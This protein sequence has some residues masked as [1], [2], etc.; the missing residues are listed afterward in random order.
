VVIHLSHQDILANAVDAVLS[1]YPWG[2]NVDTITTQLVAQLPGDPTAA[3]PPSRSRAINPWLGPASLL[4]VVITWSFG[5][6]LSKQ[7]TTFP[8]VSTSVRVIVA[9]LVQWVI[10]AALRITPSRAVL[11]S[12]A[13]PGALFCVNNML[14]FF[15]LKHASV[16][17]TVLL[18]SLQPIVV[19]FVAQPLF[20]ERVTKWDVGWT[21]VSLGGAAVAVLGANAGAHTV[22][23]SNLG[24][25]FALASML[26]F[27]GY[28]L[29]GKLHNSHHTDAA[30]NPFTYMTAVLTSSGLTS[31][32]F[33]LLSGHVKDV[34]HITRH[35]AFGLSLVIVVPT[36]GHVFLTFAHR[37]VDASVSSLVLLVQPI[38]S[39]LLAWWILRERLVQAQLVGGLIVIVGIAAVTLR[40]RNAG[41]DA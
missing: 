18:A 9:A 33:L 16:A 15:A 29:L 11:K 20:G 24:A 23:T 31:I 39:G 32:P 19:L 40:K 3:L 10:C 2:G 26:A 38:T 14:F 7:V 34:A 1:E 28:F 27:S 21:L 12:A 41:S 30:P 13:L 35:Q 17:T 36:I 5:P 22:H 37:H 8:V 6:T 4:L 25:G